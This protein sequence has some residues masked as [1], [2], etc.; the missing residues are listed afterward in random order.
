[1]QDTEKL[2]EIFTQNSENIVKELQKGANIVIRKNRDNF[3]IYKNLL[4]R[5][6]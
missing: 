5:I 4:K 6:K 3:V 1:M 2:L